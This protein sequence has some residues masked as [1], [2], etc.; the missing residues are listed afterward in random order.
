MK[1]DNCTNPA[2]YLIASPAVS[3]VKYCARCLP[4]HLK[5][6]AENGDFN[7]VEAVESPAEVTKSSKKKAVE[8]AVVE[9]LV[10]EEPVVEEPAADPAE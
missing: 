5:S 8:E 4:A 3:D 6:Q 7:I 2:I 10:V 9:E 1:C